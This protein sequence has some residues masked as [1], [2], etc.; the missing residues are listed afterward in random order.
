M[1]RTCANNLVVQKIRLLNAIVKS[2]EEISEILKKDFIC[3]G[4]EIKESKKLQASLDGYIKATSF[5]ICPY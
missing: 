2:S 3:L 4:L 5:T 1:R